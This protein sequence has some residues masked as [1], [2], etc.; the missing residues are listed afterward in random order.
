MASNV[1]VSVGSRNPSYISK[2]IR[3]LIK[4]DAKATS[5]S[6]TPAPPLHPE[7]GTSQGEDHEGPLILLGASINHVETLLA[8][9]VKA[10][11]S[12]TTEDA[13]AR[14]HLKPMGLFS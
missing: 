4:V 6:L 7:P 2:V 14:A 13:L 9:S 5:S 12:V 11:S 8:S 3:R 10:K 1:I